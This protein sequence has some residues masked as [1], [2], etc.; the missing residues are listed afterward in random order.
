MAGITQTIQT[1]HGGISEQPDFLKLPGQVRSA[2]NVYP[3]ITYGLMKRP[4]SKLITTLEPSPSNSKWF[5][6]YR[7]AEEGSFI[8]PIDST[9]AVNIYRL[10]T[11]LE[12]SNTVSSQNTTTDVSIGAYYNGNYACKGA[13]PYYMLYNRALS[14]DEIR[15]NFNAT[16]RGFVEIK[17]C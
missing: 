5:H 12:N 6:Y 7:S 9:G 3:D 11:S 2:K 10:N 17:F 16:K 1:Y 13:L 8:G 14:E 15:Q 4:G